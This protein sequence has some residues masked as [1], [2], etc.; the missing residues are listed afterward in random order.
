MNRQTALPVIAILLLVSGCVGTGERRTDIARPSG[1]ELK[2][3]KIWYSEYHVDRT[4]RT[5]L[6]DLTIYRGFTMKVHTSRPSLDKIITDSYN[7]LALA[8]S[9]SFRYETRENGANVTRT[10]KVSRDD[11]EYIYG[12]LQNLEKEVNYIKE[13]ENF[14]P[15]EKVVLE[16]Y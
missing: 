13:Q 12:L 10:T 2:Q 3:V 1:G 5:R 8:E 16:Y 9:V 4:I 11:P 6:G 7:R 14:D 15:G